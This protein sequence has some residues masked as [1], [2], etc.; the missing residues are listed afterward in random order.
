MRKITTLYLSALLL[1]A[2]SMDRL[3]LVYHMDIQQGNILTQDMVDQLEPGMNRR[4]VEFLLGSPVLQSAF[5][6]DRWDYVYTL[7]PNAGDPVRRRLTLH[8]QGD[9]LR[10]IEGNLVPDAGNT[11]QG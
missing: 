2:C 6:P 4:Q 11:H 5:H 3:P 8:F 9:Q 1:S 7:K 10:R